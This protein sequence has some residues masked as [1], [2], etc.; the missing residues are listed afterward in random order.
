MAPKI[1][2]TTQYAETLQ[3]KYTRLEVPLYKLRKWFST[4]QK[5]FFDCKN[6]DKSLCLREVLKKPD[7]P[8]F[9]VY[10]VV[11]DIT[12]DSYSFM[13]INF[14]NLGGKET[15]EHFINRYHKQLETMTKLSLQGAGRQYVDC[16]GHSY[17]ETMP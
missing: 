3:E 2:P 16:V 8:V 15:L 6:T 14:R 4:N 1:I 5:I 17:E 11:K 9:R 10:L 13:D 7:Y 12:S